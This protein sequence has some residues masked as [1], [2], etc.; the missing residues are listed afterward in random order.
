VRTAGRGKALRKA[1]DYLLTLFEV[2]AYG[3]ALL[4]LPCALAGLFGCTLAFILI[5][6]TLGAATGA[7]I[8]TT[9][10]IREGWY[11]DHL[12]GWNV[13]HDRAEPAVPVVHSARTAAKPLNVQKA[14]DRPVILPREQEKEAA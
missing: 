1:K 6:I 13:T 12:S 10:A 9:I 4:L 2:T 7:V 5:P 11:F 8:L 3:S 14:A